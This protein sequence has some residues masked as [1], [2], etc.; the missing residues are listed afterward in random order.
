MF[1][2]WG[3]VNLVGVARR[4]GGTAEPTNLPQ[5]VVFRHFGCALCVACVPVEPPSRHEHGAEI[6]RRGRRAH[7]QV[8]PRLRG[9]VESWRQDPTNHIFFTWVSTYTAYTRRKIVF[10]GHFV[11]FCGIAKIPLNFTKWQKRGFFLAGGTWKLKTRSK[12]LSMWLGNGDMHLPK[13][14]FFAATVEHIAKK[15]FAK[16]HPTSH[17]PFPHRRALCI[18]RRQPSRESL[19]PG[20]NWASGKWEKRKTLCDHLLNCTVHCQKYL[21]FPIKPTKKY[22]AK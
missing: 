1:H 8:Q 20:R 6:R 12:K 3:S 7:P 22:N 14:Y 4:S 9:Q 11:T 5:K 2:F 19:S 10:F 15:V 18:W 21:F 13:E 17:L 16:I